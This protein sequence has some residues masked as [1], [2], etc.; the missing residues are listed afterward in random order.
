MNV[1]VYVRACMWSCKI[2]FVY[3]YIYKCMS[4]LGDGFF[5]IFY[6]YFLLLLLLWLA[7]VFCY[8]DNRKIR[9]MLLKWKDFK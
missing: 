1:L 5:I 3:G 8:L 6:F 4:S 7:D 9:L 2:I